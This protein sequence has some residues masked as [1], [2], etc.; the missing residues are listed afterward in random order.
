MDF[1]LKH[2]TGGCQ[3]LLPML[4]RSLSSTLEMMTDKFTILWSSENR[5]KDVYIL[6]YS[7]AVLNEL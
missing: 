4:L 6:L 1:L 5:K 2:S 7:F 3:G